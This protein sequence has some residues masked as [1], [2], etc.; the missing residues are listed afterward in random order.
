MAR[1]SAAAK[2]SRFIGILLSSPWSQT[3]ACFP[4][5]FVPRR[6]LLLVRIRRVVIYRSAFRDINI[7]KRPPGTAPGG[8]FKIDRGYP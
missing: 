1:H 8:Q 7:R 2:G 5:S 3:C 4:R 6:A